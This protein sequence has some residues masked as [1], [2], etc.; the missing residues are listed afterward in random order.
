MS[1]AE[2]KEI[3]ET[4]NWIKVKKYNEESLS[5]GSVDWR[6]A[7]EQLLNHHK[8]ETDF[9]IKTVRKLVVHIDTEDKK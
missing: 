5:D 7:Y 2:K 8:K 3:L 1:E 9:L 6:E 4:Y